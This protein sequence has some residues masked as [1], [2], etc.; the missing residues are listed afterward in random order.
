MS[1]TGKVF[2]EKYNIGGYHH[3]GVIKR[4]LW[5]LI[6]L[7]FFRS[8]LPWPYR[9]KSF[10]L[11]CFGARTGTGLIIKPSVNIKYPWH[12]ATGDHVWLGENVWIDNLADVSIG[13][14]VCVSQGAHIL[15]G[16]HDY[17][18]PVFE[19]RISGVTLE[20][21]VWVGAR[22]LVG[23]GV[24]MR[25]HSVLLAGGVIFKEGSAHMVYGGNPAVRVHHRKIRQEESM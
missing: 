8:A 15:T 25:S 12:F 2:L 18:S 20:D 21:G 10:L 16:N 17:K 14:S 11:R 5:Y 6:S 7:C 3:G 24:T 22:S 13:N 4:A 23:P 1:G 19:L 9:F